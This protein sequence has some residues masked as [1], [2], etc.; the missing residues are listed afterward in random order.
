M[1]KSASTYMLMVQW[2]LTS[3]ICFLTL[4]LATA[5]S[6]ESAMLGLRL[7]AGGTVALN[8]GLKDFRFF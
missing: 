6:F 8:F 7:E 2:I 5:S 1:D 4:A 3:I